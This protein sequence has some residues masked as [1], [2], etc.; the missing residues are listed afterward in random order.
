[1]LPRGARRVFRRGRVPR[2]REGRPRR[3][4][5]EPAE[6]EA[7]K[8]RGRRGVTP[9][10]AG[11]EN[12]MQCPKCAGTMVAVEHAGVTVDRCA[13]CGGLWFDALE[14]LTLMKVDGAATV[15]VE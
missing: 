11:R 6:L 10:M 12:F 14:H 5:Q 7:L 3:F 8:R 13:A 2:L 1:R 15:D 4:L 9:S